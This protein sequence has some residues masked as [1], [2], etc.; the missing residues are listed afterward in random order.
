[1]SV[2]LQAFTPF[3]SNLGLL[4]QSHAVLGRPLG[5]VFL[6][7]PIPPVVK[8]RRKE[9]IVLITEYYVL[10]TLFEGGWL[11][12]DGV[13]PSS[14]WDDRWATLKMLETLENA[15][16]VDSL[17]SHGNTNSYHISISGQYRLQQLREQQER[18]LKTTSLLNELNRKLDQEKEDR[19]AYD[20]QAAKETNK[21]QRI[22]RIR[23]WITFTV[24]LVG[25]LAAVGSLI[26]TIV[27]R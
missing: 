2:A 15:G 5:G 21:Q 1:M 8:C 25:T 4:A 7:T 16:L 19:I 6:A 24:T 13:A 27:L 18:E 11:T 20:R 9:V 17:H 26:A 23:F 12:A 10:N 14:E 3:T 22:D